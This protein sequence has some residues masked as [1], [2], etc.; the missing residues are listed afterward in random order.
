MRWLNTTSGFTALIGEDVV[1]TI[2]FD[3]TDW[4][5]VV[6]GGETHS[7]PTPDDAKTWL[8]EALAE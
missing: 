7:F 4:V 1:G 3:G 2:T 6:V 8:L 5:A